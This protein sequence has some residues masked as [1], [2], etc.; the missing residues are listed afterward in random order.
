MF[1]Q[2]LDLISFEVERISQAMMNLNLSQ[3]DVVD[4]L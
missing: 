2:F 3:D 1:I 4:V